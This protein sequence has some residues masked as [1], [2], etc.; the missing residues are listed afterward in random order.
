MPTTPVETASSSSFPL[1]K[2]DSLLLSYHIRL[3]DLFSLVGTNFPK[4]GKASLAGQP[5]P[6][7]GRSGDMRNRTARDKLHVK[8]QWMLLIEL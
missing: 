8:R 7:G 1:C 4:Q 2:F 5:V 3:Y 6:R